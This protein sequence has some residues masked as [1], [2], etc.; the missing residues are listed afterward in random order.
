MTD[1][2]DLPVL[3]D[4]LFQELTE[5][6]GEAVAGLFMEEYFRMLPVRAAKIFKGCPA[7]TLSRP[8]KHSSA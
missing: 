1:D 4:G 3:A 5:D 8:W 2:Q 6:A 7:G